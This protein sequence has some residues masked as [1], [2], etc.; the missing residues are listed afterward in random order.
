MKKSMVFIV[1]L[2]W[3]CIF[4]CSGES[5]GADVQYKEIIVKAD[6]TGQKDATSD[7]QSYLNEARY[8][9]TET[10][11]YK[12]IIP[13]GT[14]RLT[15]NLNIFS[16]TWLYLEE[17]TTMLRCFPKGA[18]LKNGIAGTEY[19][20]YDSFKNI[21]LEGGI[22]EGNCFDD[23]YGYDK[24]ES[25][26][27]IRIAHASNVEFINVE[28][29]NNKGGHHLEFGGI[30][31]LTVRD[32]KFSG[33]LED[34]REDGTY[35]GKEVI[36]LDVLNGEHIFLGYEKFDDSTVN[37]V[38]I[39]NNEFIDVSRGIGSH[40]AV[41]GRYYDNI[42]IRNNTFKNLTQ[43]AIMAYNFKNSQITDNIME[44]V[45]VGIDFKYMTKD[46]ANFFM[47]ND[48]NEVPVINS[49]AGTVIKNNKIHT[50]KTD[51]INTAS[52][53]LIYGYN[54][55]KGNAN[56]NS[57]NNH[58]Y[59][60]ENVTVDNNEII[61]EGHAVYLN[62]ASKCKVTNNDVSFV[63]STQR[64]CVIT[65][66]DGSCNNVISGN[67]ILKSCNGGI[68]VTANSH[69]NS[70]LNN[71]VSNMSGI[72][73]RVYN[74]SRSNT[75]S[76]N[77]IYNTHNGISVDT[78][79][80]AAIR[81]NKIYK[82]KNFGITAKDSIYVIIEGNT[83]YSN[84]SHGVDVR[85][86]ARQNKINKNTIYSNGTNGIYVTNLTNTQVVSNVIKNNAYYGIGLGPKTSGVKLKS[87]GLSGN[88]NRAI[89]SNDNIS[90]R[91][92]TI[93]VTYNKG[94]KIII[95]GNKKSRVYL[96]YGNRNVLYKTTSAKGAATFNFVKAYK[97]KTVRLY[98]RDSYANMTYIDVKVK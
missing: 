22:W 85:N 26:S 8:N 46:G 93:K 59:K 13:K 41:I 90:R 51:Y 34:F 62:N 44:N 92:E 69:T 11:R 19:Y 43:Q 16:N 37:N 48:E 74:S 21:K 33:Y 55:V 73:I 39:E 28:V 5:Y 56:V 86:S 79:A 3:M 31:G 40:S 83:V 50:V 95:T 32:C 35:I 36:Q 60:V 12:V 7:I 10:I 49:D 89:N 91:M 96:K 42:I 77:T 67:K 4:V 97:N 17:G 58:N 80:S 57:I 84:S 71:V 15:K 82:N 38:V 94:N 87:N 24:C 70:I 29:K 27:T 65:L 30:D 66:N 53:L 45:G 81:N 98:G 72:G 14:Y 68:Y 63:N 76:G 75:V 9:A 88:K 54:M 1:T 20:G 2:M 47:P 25:F 78:S 23:E 6:N 18:M 64:Y 61:S 52:A